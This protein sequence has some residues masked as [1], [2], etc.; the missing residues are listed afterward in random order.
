MGGGE[1]EDL[2]L[3]VLEIKHRFHVNQGLPHFA[4][5]GADE[6]EGDGELEEEAVD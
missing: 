6:E 4:V 5:D 3:Y 2:R 1:V